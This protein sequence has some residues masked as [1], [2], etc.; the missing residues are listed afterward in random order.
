MYL[1]YTQKSHVVDWSPQSCA[2][3]TA[4]TMAVLHVRDVAPRCLQSCYMGTEPQLALQLVAD[5]SVEK[6]ACAAFSYG[7]AY[8]SAPWNYLCIVVIQIWTDQNTCDSTANRLQGTGRK[9]HK[10]YG[11]PYGTPYSVVHCIYTVC[12]YIYIYISN[13][14]IYTYM[15]I[16]GYS[17]ESLI[18]QGNYPQMASIQV[19]DLA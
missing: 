17:L 8:L 2:S 19:S 10:L 1:I 14:Y 13:I 15:Y 6:R 11:Y 12:M 3:S 18:N 16:L 5:C 9:I 4:R 7:N